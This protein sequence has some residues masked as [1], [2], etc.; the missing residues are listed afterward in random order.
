MGER[1]RWYA[2]GAPINNIH[3]LKTTH[4]SCR[5]SRSSDEAPPK[6]QMGADWLPAAL[7]PS[8][9]PYL[10]QGVAITKIE[11]DGR[12][13]P[14]P[15]SGG[16]VGLGRLHCSKFEQREGS[17][18]ASVRHRRRP[19]VSLARRLSRCRS[20]TRHARRPRPSDSIVALSR[21]R[22]ATRVHWSPNLLLLGSGATWR[23]WTC[24]ELVIF[25]NKPPRI[26]VFVIRS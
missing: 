5:R 10:P 3:P 11:A 13:S 6:K 16:S 26:D 24:Q 25:S 9:T 22:T 7:G 14:R 18:R 20:P 15:A 19:P 23:L 12:R 4:P 2:G 8:G 17:R 1:A 21:R